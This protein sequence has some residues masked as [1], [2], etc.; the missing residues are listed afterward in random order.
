MK[1]TIALFLLLLFLPCAGCSRS[2]ETS[3][4]P[5]QASIPTLKYYT[6]GTPDPDLSL[7]NSALN[8]LL[9]TKGSFR[10][11]I[12]KIGWDE[13]GDTLASIINSGTY[14]DLAFATGFD[15]GDFLGNAKKGCWLVLDPY[16][17]TIGKEMYSEIDP[18]LWDGVKIDGK[19][20]GVPTNKEIAV[21]EWWIYNKELVDKY[22]VDITKYRTLESLEPLFAMIQQN[23]PDF[24]VMELNRMSHNFFSI[25]G[26]EYVIDRSIPL[27]LHSTDGSTEIVNIFETETAE[28]VLSTLR[29][30][31]LAGYIDEGAAVQPEMQPSG[32]RQ[33]FWRQGGGGPNSDL[34]WTKHYGYP[35][36]SQQVTEALITSESVRGGIVAVS[37]HTKYPEAC[38]AFL[39]L[40]NTDPEVRNLLNYGLEGIH[41]NLTPEGQVNV[42]E[43]SG[44][45]GEQYTLGNW[46]I[47]KTQKGDPLNK[48]DIYKEFNASAIKSQML[49][50]VPDLTG[51]E[52]TRKVDAV[53]KVTSKYYSALMTGAVD[54][55]VMLPLFLSELNQA[56]IAYIR[57]ELQRQFDLWKDR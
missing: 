16:L 9:E 47:L 50:F 22:A 13:Y 2:P 53:M 49:Y 39:N 30:Y 32:T 12:I 3:A 56:G 14:F 54:P 38:V 40:I 15:Q 6:I 51:E 46:F 36:V 28:R 33:M 31:Y 45:I 48:W 42:M 17:E 29:K 5:V 4:V 52:F 18:V 8:K 41:Y 25:D 10:V 35:V 27:M 55:E 19:I 1:K 26:Y 24:T 37:A 43:G 11:E 44:Y 7:V 23:E 34:V 21:P 57:D 20:C